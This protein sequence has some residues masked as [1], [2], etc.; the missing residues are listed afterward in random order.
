MKEHSKAA[1][2]SS[3]ISLQELLCPFL[4]IYYFNLVNLINE[5]DCAQ[6]LLSGI[7][8]EKGQKYSCE[9]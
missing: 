3:L 6:F 1:D 4:F 5:D 2:L 9:K 8:V 7:H